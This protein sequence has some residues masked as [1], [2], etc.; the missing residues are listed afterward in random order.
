[1]II[2]S[3][4]IAVCIAILFDYITNPRFATAFVPQWL[5]NSL[6]PSLSI[7]VLAITGF[8]HPPAAACAVIY[9]ADQ[10]GA[11]KEQVSGTMQSKAT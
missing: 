8:T 9:I 11:I 7:T 4:V 3:H 6:V 5:A 10:Q 1:M 2:A